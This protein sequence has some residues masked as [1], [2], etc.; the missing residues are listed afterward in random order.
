MK[1]GDKIS[2]A[3]KAMWPG[4]F[5]L[6]EEQS[7]ALDGEARAHLAQHQNHALSMATKALRAA[8]ALD[9]EQPDGTETYSFSVSIPSA[10]MPTEGVAIVAYLAGDG[11]RKFSM[12]HVGGD[13]APSLVGLLEYGKSVL[14]KHMMSSSDDDDD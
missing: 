12:A 6:P 3:A 4:L 5:D 1:N 14:V 2:A 13:V 10:A 8:G 11:K 7:K 9:E